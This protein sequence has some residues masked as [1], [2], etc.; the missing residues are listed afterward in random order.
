[1]PSLNITSGTPVLSLSDAARGDFAVIL[2]AA[3]VTAMRRQAAAG[4][5]VVPDEEYL[6]LARDVVREAYQPGMTVGE[7]VAIAASHAGVPPHEITA[8]VPQDPNT[9]TPAPVQSDY[10]GMQD[11]Q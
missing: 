3:L 1:M 8:L 2:S 11:G 7:W 4:R 9:N 10:E 6:T 5:L